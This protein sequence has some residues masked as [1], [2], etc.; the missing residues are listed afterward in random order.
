VVDTLG[1]D[2]F[3]KIAIARSLACWMSSGPNCVSDAAD[4]LQD[5]GYGEHNDL[6]RT[7]LGRGNKAFTALMNLLGAPWHSDHGMR[8]RNGLIPSGDW[9]W[10]RVK[11]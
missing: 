8:G 5:A 7:V 10:R 9:R 3:E 6:S 2:D 11:W 4:M 1:A